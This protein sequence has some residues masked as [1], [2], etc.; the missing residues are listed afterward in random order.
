MY[1]ANTALTTDSV[2]KS[3]RATKGQH[4]K[5]FEPAPS[6]ASAIGKRGRG[7]KQAKQ[8]EESQ[9]EED[10]Q[11]A[12][13]RCICGSTEE[14]DDGMMICCDRCSSWQHNECMEIPED[15]GAI[16]DN[17][18]CEVC[19]PDAHKSLLERVK[20]GEKPWEER[21]RLREEEEQTKKGRKKQGAKRASKR[22]RPSDTRSESTGSV[23]GR[24]TPVVED[25]GER[26]SSRALSNGNKRKAGDESVEAGKVCPSTLVSSLMLNMLLPQSK[27]RKVSNTPQEKPSSNRRT[28]NQ[29]AAAQRKSSIPSKQTDLVSHPDELHNDRRRVFDF[30]KKSMITVLE[31][32]VR[33]GAYHIPAG[34]SEDSVAHKLS[35][36][37]EHAL[38]L[39]HSSPDG[40]LQNSY[41]AQM[42]SVIANLKRNTELRDQVLQGTVSMNALS[43]MTTDQMAG[44]ELI[45]QM[46]V[47]K[48]EAEKQHILVQ[49]E[50]PRIRRTHKGEEL[51]ENDQDMVNI[52]TT[53]ASR[54]IRRRESAV[55]SD[56]DAGGQME[57]HTSPTTV[58]LPES[59]SPK[60]DVKATSPVENKPLRVDTQDSPK[61][62]HT[63][64]NLLR[65]SRL[66]MCGQVS[67]N[68]IGHHHFRWRHLDSRPICRWQTKA[69]EM[70]RI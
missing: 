56:T 7:K 68:P 31:Q 12:I 26:H 46:E 60:S 25:S 11:E 8:E 54:P 59:L 6:P 61:L 37:F 48:K 65:H 10:D 41:R 16:P 29:S 42:A 67:R 49:E 45:K 47:M 27:L 39:S 50:G 44:T 5:I 18:L 30:S 55:E 69:L 13:I 66:T 4:T 20:N 63:K 35:L 51:V 22:G 34:Q 33:D 3:K 57:I 58:E 21:A 17:Y 36:E 24:E 52:E 19:D 38:Y 43:T 15:E 28:S 14:N 64:E 62:A 70:T 9:D 1:I 40:T 2:R 53:F 23:N 32:A